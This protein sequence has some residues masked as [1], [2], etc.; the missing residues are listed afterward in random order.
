MLQ[1]PLL[2]KPKTDASTFCGGFLRP[3]FWR[4]SHNT[5]EKTMHHIMPSF[6][7]IVAGRSEAEQRL[8]AEDV[9]GLDP[10]S[11]P[12]RF[13]LER[14]AD[15]GTYVL[16]V[17][18]SF[19]KDARL[20]P[21]TR[22]MLLL[23]TGWG[24]RG[25]PLQTTQGTIAKHLRR[26]VRQVFRYIKEAAREG[27]LTYA[28]TKNRLGMITG[29]KIYLSFALLR[30]NLKRK[31][32]AKPTKPARTPMAD[33]NTLIKDSYLVDPQ[34]GASLERLWK[35]IQAEPAPPE[36]IIPLPSR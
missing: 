28:Y 1:F 24:G 26:S 3:E 34:M 10:S 32:P 35:S 23:L 29:L 6:H 12:R 8:W 9:L 11:L 22:I 5:K 33:T 7:T 19:I 2:Q 17:K 36:N 18:Q 31:P 15:N 30:P 27:Y 16:P 14:P 20:M 4:F 21:G 25:E 13:F